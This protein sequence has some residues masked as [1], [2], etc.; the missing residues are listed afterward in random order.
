[1]AGFIG[2]FYT[3]HDYILQHT[4][5]HTL[6]STVTSSLPLL[7]SGFQRRTFPFLWVPERFPASATSFSQQQLTTTELQHF[8]VGIN[9]LISKLEEEDFWEK[10]K[11]VGEVVRDTTLRGGGGMKLYHRFWR[12]PGSARLSF[13]YRERILA[14]F[15]SI[16]II[17]MTLE[18]L[19]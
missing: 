17:D 18:G 15:C 4:Q 1:M 16:Y 13:W 12:F 10:E 7:C 3:E 2:L 9:F 5:T 19:H 6:V 14:E 8:P 11:E